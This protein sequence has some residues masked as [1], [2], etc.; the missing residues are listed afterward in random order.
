MQTPK[1]GNVAFIDYNK[2]EWG[3][4]GISELFRNGKSLPVFSVPTAVQ[5]SETTGHK[6][7]INTFQQETNTKFLS[8]KT[9]IYLKKKIKKV[10]RKGQRTKEPARKK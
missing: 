1:Q 3:I 10:K 9:I 4:I 5:L 2:S 7:V 8:F 6:L